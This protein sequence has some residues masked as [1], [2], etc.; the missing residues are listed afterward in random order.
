MDMKRLL[1]AGTAHSLMPVYFNMVANVGLCA[2]NGF[3][4]FTM[5][6]KKWKK[7]RID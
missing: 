6:K 1:D 2:L 3:W 7:Q 4:F 5:F